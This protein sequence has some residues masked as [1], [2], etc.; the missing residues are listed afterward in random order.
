LERIVPWGASKTDPFTGQDKGETMRRALLAAAALTIP[1]SG[2]IVGL[3]SPAFASSKKISC[4][5]LA[6][7]VASITISGCTGG[8]TGGAS[9]PFSGSVLENGGTITWVSGSTSTFGKPV[10]VATSA[11]KCPGYVKG[12]SSNPT[13]DKASVPVTADTGDGIKIPGTAKGTICISSGDTSVSSVKK[14]TIT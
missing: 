14:F 6:G 12:G 10:L 9:K 13:A 2:L 8:N 11:K 7:S 3:S 4:T 5:S 1:I